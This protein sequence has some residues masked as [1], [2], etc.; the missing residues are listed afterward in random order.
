MENATLENASQRSPSLERLQ[1][2][3]GMPRNVSYSSFT[4]LLDESYETGLDG[5]DFTGQSGPHTTDHSSGSS[6]ST[7]PQRAHSELGRT[8]QSPPSTY[9]IPYPRDATLEMAPGDEIAE[10]RPVSP[11]VILIYRPSGPLNKI[12]PANIRRYFRELPGPLRQRLETMARDQQFDF[13]DIICAGIANLTRGSW[14]SSHIPQGRF[15]TNSTSHLSDPTSL[16]K[17]NS[18]ALS[19]AAGFN[20]YANNLR[21]GR[22]SY[23]ASIFM[24]ASGL[25]FDFWHYLDE[26]STSPLYEPNQIEAS[27][28]ELQALLATKYAGVPK[29]LKPVGAQITKKHHPYLDVLPFPM[30]RQRAI[31]AATTDPP[32]LDED[33][34]CIDLMLN[35]GLVCWGSPG[36]HTS[37]DMGTPW[38]MRSWEAKPWFLKK[39]WWLVGDKD[40]V[41]WSGARWWH[42]MRRVN[43]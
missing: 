12:A 17:H 11:G 16:Q 22:I 41:M 26:D 13:V 21:I 36:G 20:P 19:R 38:D 43:G 3:S 23:F 24:N 32:L 2:D 29:D 27:E 37:M 7:N 4:G 35:D 9:F 28:S 25:G 33:D 6:S 31:A 18:S 1:E 39:W 42:M 5:L 34:L 14:A 40:D 30:F 8:Y 15:G 10:P